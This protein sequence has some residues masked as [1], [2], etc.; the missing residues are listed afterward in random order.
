V[1]RLF[2]LLVRLYPDRY[3]DRFG[4]E[5]TEH[6][7][8]DLRRACT[9]GRWAALRAV[10]AITV[11]LIASAIAERIHPTPLGAASGT[12]YREGF[13]M[14]MGEWFREIRLAVRSLARSPGFAAA[15]ILTLS[16]ALGANAAIF[17]V[18]DTV[19]LEPL[20]FE[21]PGELVSL[22]AS[23]PGSDLPDEFGLGAEFYLDFREEASGLDGVAAFNWFTSTFRTPERVERIP[24]STPD[25]ELFDL[26]GVE[27]LLGRIPDP[28]MDEAL[29]SYAMW[30]TWFGRDPGVVG[31]AYPMLD[32]TTR[33][34]VGV[35]D[36]DFTF[37][38]DRVMVWVPTTFRA[39]NVTPGNFGMNVVARLADG[40]DAESVIPELQTIARRAPE[41]W[42]GSPRYAEVVGNIV[43]I[44]R[45]LEAE[46]VGEARAPLWILMSA[47]GLVLLIAC[48]N[49]ANLFGVRAEGRGRDLAVRRAIGADRYHLVRSQLSEAVVISTLSGITALGLAWLAIPA[50]VSAVPEGLPRITRVGLDVR[51]IV[52]VALA[53]IVAGLVCG[54]VPAL[55]ASRPDLTRLRDG[56]RGSTRRASLGRD[57]LVVAQTAMALVLLTGSGLLIRS[58]QALYA[59]D[60]GY[61]VE[62]V[63]TFQFAAEEAHLV[64]GPSWAA[65]HVET[66]NRIRAMP[67]VESVGI[68]ENV[69]LDE[70]VRGVRVRT[71]ENSDPGSSVLGSATL[72]AGDYF[73]TLGIDILSGR[74]FTD[75]DARIPGNVVV[76]RALAQQLWP[77]ED[78]VGRQIESTVLPDAWHTVIGVADDVLQYD[79][80]GEPEPLM[81]YPII[82]EDPQGQVTSPG[83]VVKTERAETIAPDIRALVRE[84]APSAPMYRVYTMEGLLDRANA[85]LTFT[86]IA[87]V[88]AAGMSLLLGAIG[89]FGVLSY[90]VSQ[91]SREIGVRIALGAPTRRV[92]RMV[93]LQGA[94]VVGVGAAIGVVAAVLASRLL[95][96]VLFGVGPLDPGTFA[97]ATS[98]MVGVGLLASWLPARRASTIDPIVSMRGD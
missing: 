15:S 44:V 82:F 12:H 17:S 47:V 76:S 42:G 57:A 28:E 50:L 88:T 2:A 22:Q 14:K 29:I 60:P 63:F 43:P 65:F 20:P 81:Y 70:G 98:V 84:I 69:P 40:R 48:A 83:Y 94:K 90:V 6:A 78:P 26:L 13:G 96:G 8:E 56:S 30:T 89:L 51:V 38:D 41:K 33:E 71:G 1:S 61:D 97:A 19:L 54:L 72:A 80:R 21:E 32:G 92:Q 91:R 3:R 67:G 11:D 55:R 52:F 49:I 34:I 31:Q 27:P 46:L 77:G 16:L 7:L 86:M 64:D 24:M 74:G 36:E 73:R 18:L 62:N 59:V 25:V 68:V 5:I 75:E 58:F 95:E 87:L 10:A 45:P 35:M 37:P 85:S 39:E 53:S 23:S 66:M 79:M 93:V 9:H 4:A